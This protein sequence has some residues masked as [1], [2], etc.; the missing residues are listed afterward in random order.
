ML[1]LLCDE[2]AKAGVDYSLIGGVALYFSGTPRT[3][4]DVDFLTVLSSSDRVD[5]LMR[6][7]GYRALHRSEDAANYVSSEPDLGQVDFL[8]A[9]RKYALEMLRRAVKTDVLGRSVK[10][11]KAEDLIGLKVQSSSNDPKRAAKDRADIE[12]LMRKNAK[13]L[14]WDIVREYFTV[15]GREKEYQELKKSIL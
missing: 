11:L 1:P 9:H 14:D 7:L 10:V 8:F 4:F 5:E 13:T 2:L 3:T 15:F 6:R 12:D